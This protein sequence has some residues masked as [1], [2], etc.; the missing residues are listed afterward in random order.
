MDAGRINTLGIRIVELPVCRMVSSAGHRIDEF[1]SWW[2]EVDR[3]RLDRDE[4]PG[5]PHLFH[6][7]TSDSAFARMKYRQL[8]IYVPV[9]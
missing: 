3:N 6:V 9:A 1:D 2:S 8:D 5:R 7:I 4:G